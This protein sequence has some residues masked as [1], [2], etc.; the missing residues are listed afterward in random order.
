MHTS[1]ARAH[2][3]PHLH[4]ANTDLSSPPCAWMNKYRQKYIEMRVLV[5]I[6]V[7]RR[8]SIACVLM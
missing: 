8:L 1:E 4:R 3:Q 5:N 7:N 6:L 2:R